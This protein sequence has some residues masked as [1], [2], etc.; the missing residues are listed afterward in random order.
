V[1]TQRIKSGS[2]LVATIAPIVLLLPLWLLGMVW[3]DKALRTEYHDQMLSR[4]IPYHDL[5]KL[6]VNQRLELLHGLR[7]FVELG[8]A[9]DKEGLDATE[10]RLFLASLYGSEDGIRNLSIAPDG[11]QRYVF[12]LTGNEQVIG[13]NLFADKRESV[14]HSIAYT[15]EQRQISISGPYELRQAG[16]GLIGRLAVY[17]NDRLWGVVA[18]ALDIDHL[19]ELSGIN[20]AAGELDIAIRNSAGDIFFGSETTFNPDAVIISNVVGNDTW[21]IAVQPPGGMQVPLTAR[22]VQIAGILLILLIAYVF[23]LMA[24]RQRFLRE[25]VMQ[26][27]EELEGQKSLLKSV[28]DSIPDMIVYK[29]A[30]GVYMGCNRAFAEYAGVT[31]QDIH[32]KTDLELFAGNDT[33][34]GGEKVNGVMASGCPMS[35]EQEITNRDGSPAIMAVINT[36]F[37][38]SKGDS[39]GVIGVSRDISNLKETEMALERMA[40]QDVLTGLP[41]RRLFNDRLIH[42]LQMAQ[43]NGTG[44]AMFFIDLDHFKQI[45]DTMGHDTGDQLLVEV[46]SRLQE[47][48]R[49]MD[50]VARFGGDEFV[51]IMGQLQEP[52][53]AVVMA[54]KLTDALLGS[55][56]SGDNELPISAS[57]GVSLYPD[58]AEDAETLVRN[59]DAAMYRAKEAGRNRYE[60]YTPEMTARAYKRLVLANDL[61]KALISRQFEVYYQPQIEIATGRIV[62]A[63]ALLRW[64]HPERGELSPDDFIHMAEETGE[65][66]AIGQWVLERVCRDIVKWQREGFPAYRVAV[67][68]SPVQLKNGS[69]TT[70]VTRVLGNTGCQAEYL[71]L[72]ITEGVLIADTGKV[73]D[74][75]N[76]L[77][78]LGISIAIDDFGTGYSSLS[79]LHKLPIDKLKIDKSFVQNISDNTDEVAI[80]RAILTLCKSMELNVVAE[81][82]EQEFQNQCLL[83][84]GCDQVQGFYY[85]RPMPFR[86]FIACLVADGGSRV[87]NMPGNRIN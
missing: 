74:Q 38:D 66:I 13:H 41:N 44:V 62:G 81:G 67:N 33:M 15:I 5:L 17:V 2:V 30:E 71:E 11:I 77:R 76:Q 12:P 59:A 18:M 45:N 56:T 10:T 21:E 70:T 84:L 14:Q 9:S 82:V 6:T 86:D 29:D 8:M 3:Y 51:V 28:M 35:Y 61:R 69:F 34:E 7:A 22:L 65:I 52:E 46:A 42:E 16:R 26:A 72:E 23:F 78:A 20:Q 32:G 25:R 87:S 83:D 39:L 49:E 63:E 48:V 79:Q 55:F 43:R 54:Q 60:F 75:L 47:H 57:I 1:F 24:S 80:M 40:S 73:I 64:N 68:L 36:P 37:Y 31:Q 53:N 19:L 4:I 50:T 85:S 58:D 27:T